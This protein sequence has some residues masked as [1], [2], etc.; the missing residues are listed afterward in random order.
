MPWSLGRTS[1][2]MNCTRDQPGRYVVP[3]PS[4]PRPAE[5]PR[6]KPGEGLLAERAEVWRGRKKER[7]L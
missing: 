7:Y 2:L 6:V 4:S 3:S 5:P 1:Q